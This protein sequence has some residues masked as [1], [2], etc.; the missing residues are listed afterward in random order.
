MWSMGQR[1]RRGSSLKTTVWMF[2]AVS[3]LGI[4]PSR[5]FPAVHISLLGYRATQGGG[6]RVQTGW[7]SGNLGKTWAENEWVPYQ[8]VIENS[9]GPALTGD[10]T[11]I[12]ISYDFTRPHDGGEFYRFIDLV[13]SI[14]V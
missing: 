6:G 3:M 12:V 7:T 13:R 14:Q 11:I 10:D 8:L 5:A 2:L 4:F 9:S 1:M